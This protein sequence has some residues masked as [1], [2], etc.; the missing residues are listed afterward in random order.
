MRRI[1]DSEITT[2][3][4][5]GSPTRPTARYPSPGR[6]TAPR[7]VGR[8]PPP[9][10]PPPPC[11]AGLRRPARRRTAEQPVGARR[12]ARRRARYHPLRPADPDAARRAGRAH[13]PEAT[14]ADGSRPAPSTATRGRSEIRLAAVAAGQ[15]GRSCRQGRQPGDGQRPGV[16]TRTGQRG[17]RFG[18]RSVMHRAR[19]RRVSSQC[20]CPPRWCAGFP[21]TARRSPGRRTDVLIRRRRHDFGALELFLNVTIVDLSATVFTVAVVCR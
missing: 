6:P 15:Q 16:A 4:S 21:A 20:S 1:R 19:R 2:P 17:G 10:R 3:P 7:P 11:R 5:T 8:R 13:G 14:A 18:K 12:S 9:P